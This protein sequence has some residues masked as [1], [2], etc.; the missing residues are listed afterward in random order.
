MDLKLRMCLFED[1][2]DKTALSPSI[3]CIRK[4]EWY[5]SHTSQPRWHSKGL[6]RFWKF[7]CYTIKMSFL[8]RMRWEATGTNW[9]FLCYH[10]KLVECMYLCKFELMCSGAARRENAMWGNWRGEL[11]FHFPFLSL[12]TIFFFF[13]NCISHAPKLHFSILAR[14]TYKMQ[15]E[16]NEDESCARDFTLHS[17]FAD[18]SPSQ[19][20]K[21]SAQASP[22]TALGSGSGLSLSLSQAALFHTFADV[23]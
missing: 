10:Q 15:P 4:R 22:T 21:P 5:E 3:L 13:V 17:T 11:W 12:S 7:Y 23:S 1:L 9:T 6:P 8:C 18:T 14:Y 19:S 2:Q 16:G 20:G